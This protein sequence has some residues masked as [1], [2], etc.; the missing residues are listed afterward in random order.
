MHL[1][2]KFEYFSFDTWY[3]SFSKTLFYATAGA[4]GRL[5]AAKAAPVSKLKKAA[6]V[7]LD[8]SRPALH[9]KSQ[10]GLPFYIDVQ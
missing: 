2:K 3:K 8:T 9:V 6:A 10:N 5:G 7:S 4:A 1:V